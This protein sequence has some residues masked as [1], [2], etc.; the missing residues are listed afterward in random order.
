M[1]RLH[2]SLTRE[3]NARRS[4][5]L[6]ASSVSSGGGKIELLDGDDESTT[7]EASTSSLEVEEILTRGG[8]GGKWRW[9]DWKGVSWAGGWVGK[10]GE[11]KEKKRTVVKQ[12]GGIESAAPLGEKDGEEIVH[13]DGLGELKEWLM[14]LK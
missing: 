2:T 4:A 10:V 11:G 1:P 5:A 3:L 6:A 9:E 14:A 12:E 8:A 7:K 13:E